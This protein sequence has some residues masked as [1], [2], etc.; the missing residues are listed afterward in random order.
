MDL[1][2]P[3]GHSVNNGISRE[4]CSVHYASLDD[5][6]VRVIDLSQGTLLAKMDIRQA[7][8]NVPVAPEDKPLLGIRWDGQ[9]FI[10]QVLPFGLGSASM[11]F[12]SIVD[13]LLWIMKKKGTS[14]P[15]TT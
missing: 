10:D 11:I 13:R 12:S 1:S 6:A 3:A 5:A 2:A 4:L 7:Y 15:Y 8:Q 14:W 9:T